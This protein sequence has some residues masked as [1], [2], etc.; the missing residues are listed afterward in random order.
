MEDAAIFQQRDILVLGSFSAIWKFLSVFAHAK[1]VTMQYPSP[2]DTSLAYPCL[3][4]LGFAL[5][6]HGPRWLR[7]EVAAPA[8]PPP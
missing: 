3:M 7:G 8:Q 4:R 5:S 1:D 2:F 6:N